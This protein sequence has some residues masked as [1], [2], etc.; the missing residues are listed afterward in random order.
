M[1]DFGQSGLG[2]AQESGGSSGRSAVTSNCLIFFFYLQSKHLCTILTA[3][4]TCGKKQLAQCICL[5]IVVFYSTVPGSGVV[6]LLRHM[7]IFLLFQLSP[8]KTIWR[9]CS[10][11]QALFWVHRESVEKFF[12]DM[13]GLVK[14]L[15]CE[16]LLWKS[17]Q[18]LCRL[19]MLIFVCGI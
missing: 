17:A 12:Q 9:L 1:A 6:S 3:S 2:I 18:A 19:W 14:Q 13:W 5:G 11:F 10:H 4:K 16:F 7:K 8:Y 15:D